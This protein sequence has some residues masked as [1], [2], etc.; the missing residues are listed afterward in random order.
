M[1]EVSASLLGA[2]YANLAEEVRRAQEAGVDSFHFDFMDGH[3][4]PN[5]ALTPRHLRTLRAY[6]DLPFWVHL[7]LDNPDH[8][9]EAFEPLNADGIIL[10]L[11]TCPN[12]EESLARVRDQGSQAGLALNPEQPIEQVRALLPLLDLL[13]ILGVQPGFGGQSMDRRTPAKVTA[14][15]RMMVASGVDLALA[16]DGGVKL[17]NASD[18]AKS[19]ARVFIMGSG[20]FAAEDMAAAVSSLKALVSR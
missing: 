9:L 10:Q 1:I 8:L 20:L 12:P 18:L 4:V 11:D 16:V 19:G 6:T 13:L 14:A 17:S 2:D 15:R 3:Y 5:L 7:E